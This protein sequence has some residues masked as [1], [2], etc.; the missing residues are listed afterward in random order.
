MPRTENGQ[1]ISYWTGLPV[2][3]RKVVNTAPMT[4]QVVDYNMVCPGCG[5]RWRDPKKPVGKYIF[6]KNCEKHSYREH[7]EDVK[8]KFDRER[9]RSQALQ[10]NK[11]HREKRAAER[12]EIDRINRAETGACI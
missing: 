2:V 4:Q 3:P 7:Y 8:R 5:D 10:H 6:I 9:K 12:A 1:K 11:T